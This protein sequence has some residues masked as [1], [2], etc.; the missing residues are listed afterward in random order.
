MVLPFVLW[1]V[2]RARDRRS[3]EEA[4]LS[5]TVIDTLKRLDESSRISLVN[6]TPQDVVVVLKD[7]RR[8]RPSLDGAFGTLLQEAVDLTVDPRLKVWMDPPPTDAAA[9]GVVAAPRPDVVYELRSGHLEPG[10]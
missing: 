4:E 7:D 3:V 8:A 5:T 2:Y 10:R 9:A 6:R 1:P